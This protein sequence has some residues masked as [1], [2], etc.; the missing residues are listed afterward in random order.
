MDLD[1]HEEESQ[2]KNKMEPG[3]LLEDSWFFGNLLHGKPRM[4]RSMS[5]PCTSS[6][7]SYEETYASIKKIPE[8][9]LLRHGVNVISRTP[10]EGSRLERRGGRNQAR[11]ISDRNREMASQTCLHRAPSL[12]DNLQEDS[13]DFHG[14]DDEEDEVEF[15]LGKLIR[16]A[17]M[18][19]SDNLPPRRNGAKI[20]G[21]TSSL[22][23]HTNGNKSDLESSK[24]EEM[25]PKACKIKK[26]S[27][28]K[29]YEEELIRGFEDFGLDTCPNVIKSTTVH[30]LQPQKKNK[31]KTTRI[32]E[33]DETRMRRMFFL[34]GWKSS[35][36]AP[37][38]PPLPR[39][40]GNGNGNGNGKGKQSSSEDMKAQIKF[41]ARAVA[42]NVRQEC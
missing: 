11:K 24:L 15:S 5:E 16:Q 6:S 25:K 34:E 30:G 2:E 29:Q 37:P 19:N 33:E 13:E 9:N 7:K 21:R 17:S 20:L 31:K 36:P 4:S 32:Q 18:K 3:E 40:S 28:F 39:W 26:H 1:G 35:A 12:P 14:D 41:W 10:S 23:I 22:S 8:S 27:S 38:P 42:S